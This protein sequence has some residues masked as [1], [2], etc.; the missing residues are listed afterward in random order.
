VSVDCSAALSAVLTIT[1]GTKTLKLHVPDKSHVIVI[2]ADNFSCAW[3]NQKVA[4]NY[5][6]TGEGAGEVMSVELQ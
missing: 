6:E 3:T 5:H 1:A 2:R 4:V